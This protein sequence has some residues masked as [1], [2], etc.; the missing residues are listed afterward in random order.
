[1]LLGETPWLNE[2]TGC[3]FPAPWRASTNSDDVDSDSDDEAVEAMGSIYSGS[4]S[5]EVQKVVLNMINYDLYAHL[6]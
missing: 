2:T 5:P 4:S 1:M 6:D 3:T